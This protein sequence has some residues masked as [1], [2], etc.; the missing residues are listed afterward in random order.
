MHE[1]SSLFNLFVSDEEKKSFKNL[2]PGDKKRSRDTNKMD[3]GGKKRKKKLVQH[4]QV[5]AL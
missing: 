5:P 1:R 3:D 4:E 2:T